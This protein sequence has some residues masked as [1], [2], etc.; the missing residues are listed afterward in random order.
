MKLTDTVKTLKEHSKSNINT[1]NYPPTDSKGIENQ[2]NDANKQFNVK[3]IH[4]LKVF[5]VLKSKT[6]N[7]TLEHNKCIAKTTHKSAISNKLIDNKAKSYANNRKKIKHNFLNSKLANNK[8]E[9]LDTI[10]NDEQSSKVT[11]IT[12]NLVKDELIQEHEDTIRESSISNIRKIATKV[13]SSP[14]LSKL[15]FIDAF[16]LALDIRNQ[17]TGITA[18]REQEEELKASENYAIHIITLKAFL[19]DSIDNLLDGNNNPDVKYLAVQI[20]NMF[21][22]VLQTVINSK[23][24]S[25]Y[26]FEI[27]RRN[28]AR[29]ALNFDDLNF[30]L[31]SRKEIGMNAKI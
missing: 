26:N 2:A 16:R 8:N 15:K 1:H 6:P 5:K 25:S 21:D 9:P 23:E 18:L 3:S 27:L 13:T 10:K 7:H 22:D 19:Q 11:I 30:I 12:P 17:I 14:I 29:L 28:S 24:F 20:D 4:P 31:I